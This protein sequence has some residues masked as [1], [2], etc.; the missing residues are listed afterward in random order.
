MKFL[1]VALIAVAA[2]T[3]MA[4][5]LGEAQIIAQVEAVTSQSKSS[6]V[7]TVSPYSIEQYNESGMCPLSLDEVLD[8]GVEISAVNGQCGLQAGDVLTG[9]L[10]KTTSGTIILE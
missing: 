3:T 1:V 4:A 2:Q 5:C 7:V 9:V 8:Q 10:V 6:C